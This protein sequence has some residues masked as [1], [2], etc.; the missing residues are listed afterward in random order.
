MSAGP[1]LNDKEFSEDFVQKM[2]NRMLTSSH[3][4]GKV[5]DS[6]ATTD[7]VACLKKRLEL[8][9]KDGNTEW[10]VDVGN[11]AMMEFAFPLHPDA[12]FRATTSAE[13]PKLNQ[14]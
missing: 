6:R 13:A 7:F 4:Y 14:L 1:G 11:F 8:Y 2:R 12:H 10:L 9:E 3:K 5:K